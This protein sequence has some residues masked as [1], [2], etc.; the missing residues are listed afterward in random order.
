MLKL[1]G[2]A[3]GFVLLIVGLLA[4]SGTV[5]LLLAYGLGL[6]V[7]WVT[8]FELFQ[9]TA[10]ALAALLAGA[11]L[12][13]RIWT[14]VIAKPYISGVPLED[15]DQEDEEDEDY[16][17]EVIVLDNPV[18]P[19]SRQTRKSNDFSNVK[20]D[21]RCPCGSGRKYKNCHGFRQPKSVQK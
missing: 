13:E 19:R 8:R 17:Q 20:P 14:A 3:L 5:L 1:I 7:S 2:A 12:M 15:D 18:I 21:D 16:D 11:I 10:L 9:A 6:L 4:V